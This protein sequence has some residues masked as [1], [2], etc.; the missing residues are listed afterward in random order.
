MTLYTSAFGKNQ[1]VKAS[2]QI[3]SVYKMHF[4]FEWN[5]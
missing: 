3:W 1:P 5:F 4:G 2:K